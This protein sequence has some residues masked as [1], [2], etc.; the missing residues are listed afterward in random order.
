M[1]KSDF[2]NQ[3]WATRVSRINA[4]KRLL[5][6][7]RFSQGI[8]IYY[9]CVTIVFS[10]LSLKESDDKLSLMTVLMTISLLI[11]ILYLN[12]LKYLEQAREYRKNYTQL[13]MLELELNHVDSQDVEKIKEIEKRYCELL[14]S[15]SN[16]ISYDYYCT[17][18]SSSETYRKTRWKNIA[19][20]F[21]FNKIWRLA[22]KGIIIILPFI[23]YTLCEVF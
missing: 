8:N 16:H 17:V 11:V 12:S 5:E 10:I 3:I 18:Y 4:E 7:E 13:H 14:D 9:S 22:V 19:K 1:D 20:L 15:A 21:Y 6:K 23:L 2:Q